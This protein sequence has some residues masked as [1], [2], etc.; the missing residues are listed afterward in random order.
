M[1]CELRSE[2]YRYIAEPAIVAQQFVYFNEKGGDCHAKICS[3]NID[4]PVRS[5]EI[6][7][8]E[9]SELRPI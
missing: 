2:C 7:D 6:A 8:Q 5:C 1:N 9:N 4:R 3:L